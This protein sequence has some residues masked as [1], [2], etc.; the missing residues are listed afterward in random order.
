M[1]NRGNWK[2]LRVKVQGL[3]NDVYEKKSTMRF[4]KRIREV[5]YMQWAVTRRLV[6]FE[7]ENWEQQF[8]NLRHSAIVFL[9]L[10]PNT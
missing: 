3:E 4:Y 8:R 1:I 10:L 2:I 6:S 9:D 5:R 7:K